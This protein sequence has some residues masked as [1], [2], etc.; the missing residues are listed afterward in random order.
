MWLRLFYQKPSRRQAGAGVLDCS[1]AKTGRTRIAIPSHVPLCFRLWD[2][3]GGKHRTEPTGGCCG[4]GCAGGPSRWR[5]VSLCAGG[6]HSMVLAMPDS[7]A[8]EDSDSCE[9]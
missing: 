2:E 3:P 8:I 9:R 1:L 7:S 4:V 5:V 6:R